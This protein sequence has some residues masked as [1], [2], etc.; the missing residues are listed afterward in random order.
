MNYI[1][2]QNITLR[3]FNNELITET[4]YL[5]GEFN[6]PYLSPGVTFITPALGLKGFEIVVD[7]RIEPKKYKVLDIE[8]SLLETG[9]AP[10]KVYL[11]PIALIIGQHDIGDVLQN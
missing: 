7:P 11:E 9:D 8:I 6:L 4:D 2:L 1:V 10:I 5:H 3:D